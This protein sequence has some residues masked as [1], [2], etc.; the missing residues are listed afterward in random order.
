MAV[1]RVAS[2]APINTTFP[3]MFSHSYEKVVTVAA[4]LTSSSSNT[5]AHSLHFSLLVAMSF[6]A[7]PDWVLLSKKEER[8]LDKAAA[9]EGVDLVEE[10]VDLVEEEEEEDRLYTLE[11]AQDPTLDESPG[12]NPKAHSIEFESYGGYELIPHP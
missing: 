10:W 1:G 9:E 12:W 4:Y 2:H 3:A 6:L 8:N 7:Q 5:I 11:N